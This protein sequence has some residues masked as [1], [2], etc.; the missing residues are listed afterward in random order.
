MAALDFSSMKVKT[1]AVAPLDFSSMRSEKAIP[2]APL[3]L[4]KLT[5]KSSSSAP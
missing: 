1:E 3:D 4:S 2:Q 5:N